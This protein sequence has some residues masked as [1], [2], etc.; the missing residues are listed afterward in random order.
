[1]N[2]TVAEEDFLFIL[3]FSFPQ[4]ILKYKQIKIRNLKSEISN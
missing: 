2:K 4:I 3:H 1:M